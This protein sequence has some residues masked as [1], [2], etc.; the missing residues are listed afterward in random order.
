[1][2]IRGKRLAAV[3]VKLGYQIREGGKGDFVDSFHTTVL[4]LRNE[5]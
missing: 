1:M 3:A 2:E 5:S 4:R